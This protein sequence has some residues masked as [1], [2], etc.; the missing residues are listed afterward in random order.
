VRAE[1]QHNRRPCRVVGRREQI[2]QRRS[3]PFR[4]PRAETRDTRE[5]SK[6]FRPPSRDLGER[7]WRGARLEASE[8]SEAS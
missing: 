1:G 7:R 5:A 6:A 2:E 3:A 8:A 4:L